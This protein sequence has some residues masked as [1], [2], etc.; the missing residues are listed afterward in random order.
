MKQSAFTLLELVASIA[1][2]GVVVTLM[3]LLFADSETAWKLGTDRARTASSA[4]TALDTIVHDLEQAVADS[5]LTFCVWMD[6]DTNSV[7]YG[8]DNDQLA[9]VSLQNDSADGNRTAVGIRYWVR[10]MTNAAGVPLGRYELVRGYDVPGTYSDDVYISPLW[11]RAPAPTFSGVVA[12]NVAAFVV[13]AGDGDGVLRPSYVSTNALNHDRLP[14][15]VDVYLELLD[16]DVAR[17][18]AKMSQLGQDCRGFVDTHARR[19]TTRV[20]FHSYEGYQRCLRT[21]RTGWR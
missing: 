2:L 15:Y 10:Q 12:E 3:A 19:Y 5:K 8:S 17:R 14:S 16:D 1:I 21:L 20:Y 13:G 7:S 9:F 6:L 18:A 11:Y 4:R